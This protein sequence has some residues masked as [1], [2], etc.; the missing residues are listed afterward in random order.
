MRLLEEE[1]QETKRRTLAFSFSVLW[2]VALAALAPADAVHAAQNNCSD[3]YWAK[4]IRCLTFPDQ[5][6]QPTPNPPRSAAEV[7]DFTRV[8]LP[9]GAGDPRC[10]DGTRPVLYVDPAEGGPS[11]DWLV[12]FAG[13]G[14]CSARDTDGDGTFD[15]AEECLAAYATGERTEMGTADEP[16]MKNLGR[17]PGGG[18]DGIHSPDLVRNPVFSRFH[19][20]RVEK[21]GYDRH[22]GSATHSVRVVLPSG[23]IEVSLFQHG[24]RITESALELLRHGLRF[25]S[26][27]VASGQVRPFEVSLPPL[28]EARRILFV[29]HSGGAH[30]LMFNADAFA[31]RLRSWQGFRGDV[32]AVFDANFLPSLENEATFLVPPAGDAYD[33]VAAGVSPDVGSYDQVRYTTASPYAES[34]RAW[35]GAGRPNGDLLDSSCLAAHPGAAGAICHDRYHVLFHHLAT[36]FLVREDLSDPNVEHTASGRGHVV[37]WA[38]YGSFGHC[39]DLGVDPCPP[40][41]TVGPDSPYRRRIFEQ[42]DTFST[43]FSSRSELATG[44]DTSGPVPSVSFWIP[45]CGSHAGSFSDDGYQRTRLANVA[46]SRPSFREAI[47]RFVVGPRTGRLVAR[48][49]GRSGVS[50]ICP[51]P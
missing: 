10:L 11:N 5:V 40:L 2:G 38:D 9:A 51:T 14:S 15:S 29:G 43:G 50:S 21:C 23:E 13:G 16:R 17:A 27:R 48:V 31:E 12:T 42:F 41:L 46:G 28:A 35:L 33:G 47:E 24:R 26:Y 37:T 45:D 19:R 20:V 36:P 6:P 32:R 1:V 22:Q 7:K 39:A 25:S 34:H 44:A 8:D 49:E 30:G 4:S 18:S 3:P